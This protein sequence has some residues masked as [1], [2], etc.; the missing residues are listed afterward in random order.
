MRPLTTMIIAAAAAFGSLAVAAAQSGPV[1]KNCKEDI[2]QF[3]A[4]LPHDGSVRHCLESNY[5]KVSAACKHALDTTG[6][7]RRR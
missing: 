6:P 2:P 5:D 7:G 3:C 4:G 1:A